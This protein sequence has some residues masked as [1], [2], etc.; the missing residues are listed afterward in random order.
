MLLFFPVPFRGMHR[1]REIY[2]HIQWKN[3]SL[4]ISSLK[5]FHLHQQQLVFSLFRKEWSKFYL[6][7]HVHRINSSIEYLVQLD[8]NLSISELGNRAR[9]SCI[10]IDG[11]RIEPGIHFSFGACSFLFVSIILHNSW[12]I[13]FFSALAWSS[14][15]WTFEEPENEWL[16]KI[17]KISSGM[18]CWE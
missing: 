3:V 14:F 16:N 4:I 13:S 6:D 10:M 7:V 17:S 9:R 18:S 12:C 2:I 15:N 11:Y 5:C 1:R 8:K